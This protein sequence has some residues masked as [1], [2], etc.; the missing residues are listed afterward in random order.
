MK[1]LLVACRIR[2]Y[3]FGVDLVLSIGYYFYI[4]RIIS[5]NTHPMNMTHSLLNEKESEQHG[6]HSEQ[7]RET[8]YLRG[9]NDYFSKNGNYE[10][11][12]T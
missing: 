8:P 3:H 1:M 7:H 11:N 9:K 4:Y 2:N 12:K 10:T 5:Y 6:H